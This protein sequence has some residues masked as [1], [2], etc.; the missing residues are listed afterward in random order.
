M[1]KPTRV[2]ILSEKQTDEGFL[3]KR[4]YSYTFERY[5]GDISPL[6]VCRT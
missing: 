3:P 5:A 2:N 4:Q 6:G 1:K